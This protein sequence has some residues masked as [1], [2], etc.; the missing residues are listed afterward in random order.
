[1]ESMIRRWLWKFWTRKGATGEWCLR[2]AA[3]IPVP[4]YRPY[5]VMAASGEDFW[6]PAICPDCL[7]LYCKS[8]LLRLE[9]SE[10]G[11]GVKW[12]G[13]RKEKS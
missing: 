8:G 5:L 13:L 6:I 3:E 4:R 12:R 10:F 9:N 1:M 2:C 7:F 11:D